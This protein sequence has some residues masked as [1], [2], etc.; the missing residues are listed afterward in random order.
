[1]MVRLDVDTN[2]KKQDISPQ[3]GIK[4]KTLPATHSPKTKKTSTAQKV[5]IGASLVGLVALGAVGIY[6]ATK[7]PAKIKNFA[8]MLEE[9]KKMWDEL[10]VRSDSFKGKTIQERIKN[11]LGADS[12]IAPHTY[13][14]TKEYPAMF[15]VRDMGGFKD[16]IVLPRGIVDL[17]RAN[18]FPQIFHASSAKE[19]CD[20]RYISKAIIKDSVNG[21]PGIYMDLKLISPNDKLTPAQID[22]ERIMND[23]KLAE[24]I[25][26][27][28]DKA[29]K[30]METSKE[31]G[32]KN[33]GVF[34]HLDYDVILSIIQSLS[35][36][37]A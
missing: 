5:G 8:K 18:R 36:K 32:F 17:S 21:L 6:L 20:S 25:E 15:V 10:P 29:L 23:P 2:L 28:F 33:L 7:K 26:T 19:F 37:V 12:K 30:F 13:D 3:F 16:G 27:L 22:L 4:E 34:E 24:E 11:I 14:L 31:T 35:R 9:D 1:M